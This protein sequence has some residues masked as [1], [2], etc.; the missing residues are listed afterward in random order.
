VCVRKQ[1][2]ELVLVVSDMGMGI[3]KEA[4]SKIF[5]R[6]YRVNR[7]GKEIKGTGLG[8]AIV[9]KIVTGHSGRIEVESEIDKGTTFTVFLPL[10]PK[11]IPEALSEK[12]DEAME[13]VLVEDSNR[14]K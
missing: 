13:Q 10:V 2:D 4:L 8:L 12:A 7:P 11:S 5:E 3:P 1:D 6:F 14:P 9:K